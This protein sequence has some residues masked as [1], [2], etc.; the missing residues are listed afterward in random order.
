LRDR[1]LAWFGESTTRSVDE[2]RAEVDRLFEET[3]PDYGVVF[4]PIDFSELFDLAE[5]HRA[6]DEYRSAATVYRA[7]VEALVVAL[8]PAETFFSLLGDAKVLVGGFRP[9]VATR[10]RCAGR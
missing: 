3:N 8:A 1:F 9:A 7:L 6:Q 4:E 5:E 10:R 2:L